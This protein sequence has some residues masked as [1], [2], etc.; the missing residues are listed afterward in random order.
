MHLTRCVDPAA[1]QLVRIQDLFRTEV[2][3]TAAAPVK[4]VVAREV[5]Q[6][7]PEV[8]YPGV[9]LIP[10]EQVDSPLKHLLCCI[11]SVAP[12]PLIIEE[13]VYVDPNPQLVFDGGD[14]GDLDG[15]VELIKSILAEEVVIGSWSVSMLPMDELW[16][17]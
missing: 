16:G 7:A 15:I 13:G 4:G 17:A 6:E 3:Q 2:A 5:C 8:S 10:V 14:V 1:V 12:L 11:E 9:V